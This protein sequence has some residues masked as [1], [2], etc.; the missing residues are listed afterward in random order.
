LICLAK[1]DVQP[2]P[3]QTEYIPAFDGLRAVSIIAV[4]FFHVVSGG[5]PWLRDA[6][7]RGWYGVDVFF[8]LSGFLITWI[9]AAEVEKTGTINLQRFYIRRVL[10]LQPAYFVGLLATGVLTLFRHHDDFPLF[11]TALPFYLTYTLNLAV[12][13]RLFVLPPYGIA[14][15]L[16]IEEQFYVIWAWTL[17]RLGLHRSL[18]FAVGAV[19]VIAIY[20]S[21]L[22]V[23]LNWGDLAVA[24]ADTHARLFYSTDVR[25][26]TILAGCSI[27]IAVSRRRM[28][29]II[30]WLRECRF[31][32]TVTVVTAS[33][34]IFWGTGSAW[35]CFTLGFTVMSIATSMVVLSIFLQQ[36][37]WL[38][39]SLS[40]R[41]LVF[42][43][44]ISYGVYLFHM[45]VW[46]LVAHGLHKFSG[47]LITGPQNFAAVV[48]VLGGSVVV[49]WL[50]YNMVERHFLALRSQP[51]DLISASVS[52]DR[53][54]NAQ[55]QFHSQAADV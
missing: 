17:R 43:G 25:L 34:T 37:S 53:S 16:C 52:D 44:K 6:A 3:L 1:K 55:P 30:D 14:W 54:P 24:S 22:Y 46:H 11:L 26:D 23:W 42:I 40:W 8:V 47:P 13:A 9:L 19:V 29:P 4:I 49:A 41:P 28:R 51:R 10:R 21:V 27:A 35:R 2:A 39:R 31:F 38:A 32:P 15:S 5:P 36:H 45:L 7:H 12:A 18:R 50:H 20:R 33:A 48:L